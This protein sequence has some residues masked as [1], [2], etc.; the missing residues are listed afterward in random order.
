MQL[1]IETRSRSYLIALLLANV[2]E[3]LKKDLHNG[4]SVSRPY[5]IVRLRS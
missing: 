3:L 1:L 4:D 2:A 5:E